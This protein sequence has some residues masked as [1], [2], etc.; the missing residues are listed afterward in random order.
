MITVFESILQS[1]KPQA[2]GYGLMIEEIVKV[3]VALVLIMGFHQLFL[4]AILGLVVS[5]FVQVI[6]YMYLLR[7]EFK[8]ES[9]MGLP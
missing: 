9:K 2:V 3:G 8:A 5:C 7:G 4:G 1:M 6:Y